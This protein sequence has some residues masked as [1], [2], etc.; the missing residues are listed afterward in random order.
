MKI[1]ASIVRRARGSLKRMVRRPVYVVSPLVYRLEVKW[2][3]IA[4]SFSGE[5]EPQDDDLSL[6]EAVKLYVSL[7]HRPRESLSLCGEVGS[8]NSPRFCAVPKLL[9]VASLRHALKDGCDFLNE[10]LKL[11]VLGVHSARTPND[12][13]TATRPSGRH[14]CNSDAMAGFAAAHG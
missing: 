1:L 7:T 3:D 6:A 4:N 8:Y 9:D 5:I 2:E 13:S 14:D 10:F 11:R 12:P